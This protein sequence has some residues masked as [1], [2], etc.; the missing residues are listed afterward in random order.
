MGGWFRK[1][2]KTVN[3]LKGLKFRIGGFAGTVLQKLGVV[4]QQ[5]PGGE[6]YPAL[7][8]GTIDAAEWVGPYDD[9]K[10]GFYKVAKNYYYPGWWEGGP[11]LDLFVNTKAYESLPPEYKSILESACAEANIDMMAK[12]DAVNPAALKRLIGNGVK[13]SAFSNDVMA[14]CYKAANEVFEETAA[15]N[16]KFKKVY[17]SWVRFRNEQVQWFSIAE[18]RYDNFMVA[19]QRFSQRAPAP[20]KG[21]A[22]AKAAAKDA[23]K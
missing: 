15:S 18:N 9:E 14:A 20:A 17:D 19:A 21:A 2:I 13:L 22:P 1:E 8:K 6:I 11:E 16:P 3:D 5:I 23:K 10:L 7:E 4:P 12:Y